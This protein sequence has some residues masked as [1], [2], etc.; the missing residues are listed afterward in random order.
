MSGFIKIMHTP[1]KNMHTVGN[2]VDQ[3]GSSIEPD[4]GI[5]RCKHNIKVK[6]K[7]SVHFNQTNECGGG[8]EKL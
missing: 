1:L 4:C 7:M 3:S 8:G 6:V 2:V 5:M